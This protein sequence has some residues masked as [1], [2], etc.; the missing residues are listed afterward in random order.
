MTEEFRLQGH[1]AY[2]TKR[3]ATQAYNK[4]KE[5]CWDFMSDV[6]IQN[7]SR[8]EVDI[9]SE[10]PSDGYIDF[11]KPYVELS[12]AAKCGRIDLHWYPNQERSPS[13]WIGG[14]LDRYPDPRNAL[15]QVIYPK[16]RSVIK[17]R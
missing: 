17:Q 15:T 12:A 1:F 3:K 10:V 16:R 4:H 14:V 9:S 7:D 5:T 8:I 2:P 6:L 13:K 11:D